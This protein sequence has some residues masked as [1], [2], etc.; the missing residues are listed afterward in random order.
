MSSTYTMGQVPVG[1]LMPVPGAI[2]DQLQGGEALPQ[3]RPAGL[4]V[5]PQVPEED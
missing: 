1:E 4:Q 2:E 3:H 5:L